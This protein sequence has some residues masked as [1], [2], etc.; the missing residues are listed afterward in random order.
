MGFKQEAA[1]RPTWEELLPPVEVCSGFHV[2]GDVVMEWSDCGAKVDEAA[3]EYAA[4]GDDLAGE[5]Q[6]ADQGEELLFCAGASIV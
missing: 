6:L 2:E 5:G 3:Q 1:A 4:W